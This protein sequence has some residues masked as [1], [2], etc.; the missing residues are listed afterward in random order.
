VITVPTHHVSKQT[1]ADA[2]LNFFFHRQPSLYDLSRQEKPNI[3]NAIT[4]MNQMIAYAQEKNMRVLAKD[5]V[6]KPYCSLMA[7]V[8]DDA[9]TEIYMMN[10]RNMILPAASMPK[11]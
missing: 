3:G 6:R 1:A 8:T 11:P 10:D 7:Y 4:V 5:V 9:C 2:D